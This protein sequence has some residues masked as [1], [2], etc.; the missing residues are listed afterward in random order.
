M[1]D[2]WCRSTPR[3][4]TCNP[5]PQKQIVPNLTTTPWGQPHWDNSFKVKNKLLKFLPSVLKKRYSTWW[6]SLDLWSIYITVGCDGPTNFWGGLKSCL[7]QVEPRITE[8]SSCSGYKQLCP[9][10]LWPVSDQDTVWK[11]LQAP[12]KE[13]PRRPLWFSKLCPLLQ[14][15]ISP[16][17]PG[18]DGIP[19]L[20]TLGPWT[21]AAHHELGGGLPGPYPWGI[22]NI[23]ILRSSSL[24]LTGVTGEV[25]QM[26]CP[27]SPEVGGN[28][29]GKRLGISS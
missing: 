9:Q 17:G 14:V 6:I 24:R 13:P 16:P 8:V 15:T 11:L 21:R 3:I 29:L 4:Q 1:A 5:R 18:G 25:F 10:P 22:L 27:W 26:C 12:I 19:D 20:D 23:S 2:K 7:L 28:I